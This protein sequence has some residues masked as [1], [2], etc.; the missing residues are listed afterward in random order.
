MLSTRGRPGDLRPKP[1]ART[2][3][4]RQRGWLDFPTLY[5]YPRLRVDLLPHLT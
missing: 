2:R 4:L 5:S 1:Q 3:F